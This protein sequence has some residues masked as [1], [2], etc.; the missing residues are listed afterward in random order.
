MG[1][2]FGVEIETVPSA[3]VVSNARALQIT[4]GFAPVTRLF[5]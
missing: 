5:A 4:A 2:I 3:G 1:K